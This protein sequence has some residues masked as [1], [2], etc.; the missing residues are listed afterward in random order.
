L[1][2]SPSDPLPFYPPSVLE[3]KRCRC[4]DDDASSQL[5]ILNIQHHLNLQSSTSNI[6]APTHPLLSSSQLA[7]LNIQHH[8][9][10]SPTCVGVFRFHLFCTRS[11][12]DVMTMMHH[13][14][15]QSSTSNISAPTHPLVFVFSFSSV[16]YTKRCRC[17]DDDASSQLAILN[18]QPLNTH[19][20][21]FQKSKFSFPSVLEVKRC[22]CDD[23][24]ASSQLA[25][26]HPTSQHPLVFLIFSAHSRM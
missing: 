26:L 9:T 1:S 16:L 5:A 6:S 12:A 13:L 4:D 10:H 22:R 3:V 7:I 21:F 2:L 14:N 20:C 17:D 24:D 19:L 25:I 11:V 23:D 18:I 8:S 15:L